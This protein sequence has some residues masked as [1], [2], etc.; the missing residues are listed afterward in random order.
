MLS[1]IVM[2]WVLGH[3]CGLQEPSVP[4]V[5]EQLDLWAVPNKLCVCGREGQI[6]LLFIFFK[7]LDLFFKHCKFDETSNRVCQTLFFFLIGKT[8][9]MLREIAKDG[10]YSSLVTWSHQCCRSYQCPRFPGSPKTNKLE[11]A[12]TLTLKQ[13]TQ[14][15]LSSQSVQNYTEIWTLGSVF[16]SL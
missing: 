16:C 2:W 15:Y 3:Q 6:Q 10:S 13:T 9:W 4:R 11:H 8:I 7:H 12:Q 14:V 1:M 5:S